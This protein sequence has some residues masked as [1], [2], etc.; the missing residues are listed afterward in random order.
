M[1]MQARAF[2]LSDARTLD[3]AFGALAKEPSDALVPCWDGATRSLAKA[4]AEFA[5]RTRVPT[6]GAV[7]EYVDAGALLSVGTNL[8]AQRRQAAYYVD[9][10][11]KGG[12]PSDIPIEQAAAFDT[13]VNVGTAKRIGITL[14]PYFMQTVEDKVE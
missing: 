6:V 9:R 14:P 1:G 7:R 13:V 4:I 10:I 3:A 5:I 2:E 8:A 11:R 12:K